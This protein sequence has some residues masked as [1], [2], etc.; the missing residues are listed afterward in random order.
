MM[1]KRKKTGSGR[2]WIIRLFQERGLE[3]KSSIVR[4]VLRQFKL[5]NKYSCCR[6]ENY[7]CSFKSLNLYLRPRMK[8]FRN[9]RI[10][11]TC[12]EW[13]LYFM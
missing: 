7:F 12:Q 13:W 10:K 11:R 5:S 8:P 6:Y 1:A 9:L 3:V 4:N 2:T